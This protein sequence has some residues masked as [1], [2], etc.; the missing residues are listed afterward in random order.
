MNIVVR[1][2]FFEKDGGVEAAGA[3]AEEEGFHGD[4]YLDFCREG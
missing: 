2:G 1:V 3:A 4:W